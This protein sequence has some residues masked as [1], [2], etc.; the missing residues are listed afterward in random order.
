MTSLLNLEEGRG[1]EGKANF[2]QLNTLV[3][4]AVKLNNPCVPSEVAAG[5]PEGSEVSELEGKLEA[6]L[7]MK[8]N[9]V[10]AYI[11]EMAKSR[12]G[13]GAALGGG[14]ASLI[15]RV[16]EEAKREKLENELGKPSDEKAEAESKQ[17]S[18]EILP[19]GGSIREPAPSPAVPS[20]L[21]VVIATAAKRK[22]IDIKLG[23]T[24][25]EDAEIRQLK[26]LMMNV[27]RGKSAPLILGDPERSLFEL[28]RRCY[29]KFSEQYLKKK[30]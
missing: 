17:A 30:P 16:P 19:E 24:E 6:G 20:A 22:G 15:A 12:K 26:I 13:K 8:R 10:L 21:S 2:D 11:H 3:G 1:Q 28:V 4:R 25:E 29:K 27:D 5:F 18:Y 14:I 7:G 9:D 23:A